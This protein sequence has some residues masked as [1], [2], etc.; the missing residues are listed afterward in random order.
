MMR[1]LIAFDLDECLGELILSFLEYYNNSYG[2]NY[3][4]EDVRSYNLEELIGGTRQGAIKEV[5]K[6]FDTDY[7]REIAVVIGSRH[8]V[9]ELAKDNEVIVITSRPYIVEK[10][11]AKWLSH[12]FYDR[13]NNVIF[14]NEWSLEGGSRTKG[15]ICRELG[16][17]YMIEDNLDYALE[18]SEK[19]IRTFLLEKPWNQREV[20][21]DITRVKNYGELLDKFN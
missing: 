12:Q 15:D 17:S 5:Y 21:R 9:R 14:T 6:F 3:R 4:Y 16:V 8:V 2:T 7:F 1:N 19:G 18:C 13:F 10:Q 20:N 11:T